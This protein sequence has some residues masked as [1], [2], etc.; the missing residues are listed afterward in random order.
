MSESFFSLDKEFFF[1]LEVLKYNQNV[2]VF[3]FFYIDFSGNCMPL[4]YADAG[5]A[6]NQENCLL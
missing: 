5:F 6:L 4:Q 2:F 3:I 1:I